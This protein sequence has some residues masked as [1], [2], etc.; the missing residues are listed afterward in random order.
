M[1]RKAK[2]QQEIE[3]TEP[4]T[5]LTNPYTMMKYMDTRNAILEMCK[6]KVTSIKLESKQQK[7][8]YIHGLN[9]RRNSGSS[10]LHQSLD[11]SLS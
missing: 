9:N 8:Y 6:C 3:Q 4:K 10:S 1:P 11:T 5:I 7:N 2:I